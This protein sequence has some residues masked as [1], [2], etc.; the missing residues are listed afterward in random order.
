MVMVKDAIE[1]FSLIPY[2]ETNGTN[3]H[4]KLS[5]DQ[6]DHYA[7]QESP[8]VFLIVSDSGPFSR[9]VEAKINTDGQTQIE[10]VFLLTQKDE[11]HLTKEELWPIDNR[12]IDQYWQRTFDFHSREKFGSPP[13]ILRN[14][15]SKSGMLLPFQPLFFCKIKQAYFQPLCPDCGIPLEQCYNDAILKKHGLQPYNGSL[16]RYLFC[17]SCVDS[18]E[19]PD[20]YISSLGDNDPAFLINRFELIKKIGRLKDNPQLASL[21]PCVNCTRHE[22]CYGPEGLAASRIVVFSFYPFYMLMFRAD[23]VNA[24]DFLSLMSGASYNELKKQLIENQQFGRLNG[25]K[26]LKQKLSVNTPFFFSGEDRYFLE[27]LY[28]KLS[29]LGELAEAVFSG[30]DTFQSPELGLSMERI[31]V[32]LSEQNNLLPCFWNFRLN[33][34]DVLGTQARSFSFPK[35]PQSYGLYLLGAVWFYTLLVNKNQDVSRIHP[36]M[37]EAI[38]KIT[39]QEDVL[40]EKYLKNGF[41]EVFAPENIFWNPEFITVN[42]KWHKFWKASLCMGF[43]LLQGSLPGFKGWSNQ[44]FVQE[45]GKLRQQIK[46][47]LFSTEPSVSTKESEVNGKTIVNMLVKIMNTWEEKHRD[48]QS[49]IK[50]TIDDRAQPNS[51]SELGDTTDQKIHRESPSALELTI[52][53]RAQPN[54]ISA[55]NAT[56]DDRAQP[57]F[58]SEPGNTTDQKTHRESLSALDS[59]IDD[60]TQPNSPSELGNT[61]DQKIHRESLSALDPTIDDRTQPGFKSAFSATGNGGI[62][63]DIQENTDIKETIILSP[64]TDGPEETKGIGQ[65]KDP[66]RTVLITCPD[67]IITDKSE[68]EFQ[69]NDHLKDTIWDSS[70][71]PVPAKDGISTDETQTALHQQLEPPDKGEFFTE[72]LSIPPDTFDPDK[73]KVIENTTTEPIPIDQLVNEIRNMYV[74]DSPH[75][76]EYIKHFLKERLKNYSHSESLTVLNKLIAEFGNTPLSGSDDFVLDHS[77]MLRLYSLMLGKDVSRLNLSSAELLKRLTQSLNTLFDSL[78]RLIKVIDTALF[79][80][81]LGKKGTRTIIVSD[82]ESLEDHL[83]QITKAFSL[84]KRAFIKTAEIKVAEILRYM[85]PDHFT[86]TESGRLKIALFR[87]AHQFEIFEDSYHKI[88]NNFESGRFIEAFLAEFEKNCQI[89]FED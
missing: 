35:L 2:L 31:W 75:S 17:P 12:M 13:L 82:T 73:T 41:P 1:S 57:N 40:L 51:S 77:K 15:M 4:I 19:N 89:L 34:L 5:F 21:L 78:D 14:Q 46:N 11:Y 18:K 24:L 74:S 33:L 58:S 54:S 3:F 52:D 27:V 86:G 22:E 62:D 59:T 6:Q 48:F 32:T 44:G 71:T 63:K 25:L 10:P 49:D 20:F 23:S 80:K 87:K 28:L 88:K 9:I 53:D 39:G 26:A 76:E 81:D 42:K 64:D 69:G 45:L 66:N 83:G 50:G 61:T 38:E 55:P 70:H 68:P 16:K 43:N 7:Y 60:R 67:E 37:A 84:A 36:A 47:N 30:L 29:F 56:K 79:G 8:P 72:T 85:D 65:D